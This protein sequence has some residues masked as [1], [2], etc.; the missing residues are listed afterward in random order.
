VWYGSEGENM[1]ITN[2]NQWERMGSIALGGAL[3]WRCLK[4]PSLTKVALA[5]ALLSRGLSGHSYLYQKL[6]I[7]TNMPDLQQR[8]EKADSAPSVERAITIGA[9]AHTLYEFWRKPENLALIMEDLVEVS[10]LDEICTRWRVNGPSGLRLEWDACIVEERPG[11]FLSW[12]SLE[13]AQIPNE[14]SVRFQPAPGQRGTEV[15]L[16]FSFNPP[17]GLPG[18]QIAQSLG[19]VPGL[20]A[21]HALRRCKSLVETGEVPTLEH[22]P[23]A[24]AYA[25]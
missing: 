23:S 5:S 18:R 19:F 4:H 3:L 7:N 17:G 21:Y 1:G 12:E 15:V 24:R 11:E 8:A 13:G 10:V 20:L 22:N 25:Q 9:D 6:G 14:G 16:R 2:V